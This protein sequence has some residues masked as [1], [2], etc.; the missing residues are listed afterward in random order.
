VS[1]LKGEGTTVMLYGSTDVSTG[2]RSYPGYLARPDLRGEWPTVIVT[3]PLDGAAS[4]VKAICRA[5]A[6]H[7]VA[8]VAPDPGGLDPF[9][10]F[11]TNPAGHWSNAEY[12]FGVLGLGDGSN[13]A[14]LEAAE[15]DLVVAVAVVD[16]VF[17]DA[18]ISKLGDVDVPMLGCSGRDAYERVDDA[19]AAVPQAEWVVYDGAG[20]G[21]WDIDADGYVSAAADDTGDRVVEFFS[22]TLPERV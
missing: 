1:V 6:R 21:Y 16:P 13:S 15:S 8:A 11:I 5:I 4:S 18:T 22:K 19:R 14:I 2:S 10:G 7:G 9:I 17:D 12:G 3:S 20:A